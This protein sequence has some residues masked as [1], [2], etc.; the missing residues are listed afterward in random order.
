MSRFFTVDEMRCHSGAEYPREWV[1]DRLAALFGVLDAIRD[2]WDAPIVVVC[3][4][5]TAA[6]NEALAKASAARNGGVSGVAL[7]SQHI[8]GRAADVRPAAPT[9]ERVA[10]LH[11]VTRH[12]FDTG[13]LPA[14][15]GLGLY[16][17]WIHVD[18]RAKVNGK[19]ATWGGTG[20]GDA[21]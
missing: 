8:Q 18:V 7:N 11:R 1:D 14:L 6:Y 16:P 9:V 5:R 4:Y 21:Q 10:E 19:L 15:G 2:A 12:L 20:A 17:G 3:G 13:R